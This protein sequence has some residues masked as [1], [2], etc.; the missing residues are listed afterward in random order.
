MNLNILN[1]KIKKK[2]FNAITCE[3]LDILDKTYL[4]KNHSSHQRNKF[5]L[6]LIIKS[7]ELKKI[8]KIDA[9]KKIYR[10]LSDE[11]KDYIHSIQIQ[12]I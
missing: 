1:Q 2:I 8:N 3:S 7:N 6:K 5:H 9:N 11:I 10:I 4:H 12:L